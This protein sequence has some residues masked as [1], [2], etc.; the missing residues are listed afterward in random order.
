MISSGDCLRKRPLEIMNLYRPVK[1]YRIAGF[2]PFS[3]SVPFMGSFTQ[4]INPNR[5]FQ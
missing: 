3:T 1:I 4:E 5:F 2:E